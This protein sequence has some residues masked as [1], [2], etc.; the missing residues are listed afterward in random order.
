MIIK[1]LMLTLLS[2]LGFQSLNAQIPVLDWAKQIGTIYTDNSSSVLVDSIGNV[3]TS[4]SI[5]GVLDIDPGPDTSLVGTMGTRSLYI[6]KLDLNG[7]LLWGKSIMSQE[8]ISVSQVVMDQ[9]GHLILVGHFSDSVDFD[10]GVGA[11]Y[12][13]DSE[14]IMDVFILKLDSNGEFIWVNQ[15][16]SVD[17]EERCNGVAVDVM[18]NVYVIGRFYGTTD[19]DPGPDTNY[20]SAIGI[21]DMFINKFDA[22]GNFIWSKQILGPGYGGGHSIAVDSLGDLYIA[23]LFSL[24]VDFDPGIDITTLT[25]FEGPDPFILKLKTDG[26]LDW[27]K[28]I[29]AS[30]TTIINSLTLDHTANIYI[31]GSF[32]DTVDFNYGLGVDTF[33]SMGTSDVFIQKITTDGDYVW[34]KHMGSSSYASGKSIVTDYLGNIYTSGIFYQSVDFDPGL[35]TFHVYVGGLPALFIQKLDSNGHFIWVDISKWGGPNVDVNSIF[36]D[37]LGYVY[38]TG[39]FTQTIGFQSQDSIV[40][41]TSQGNKD[42]F[43]Q[44]IAQCHPAPLEPVTE[45]L[46]P[47]H[48]YCSYTP[49]FAPRANNG[50]RSYSGHT[51]TDFPI[52]DPTITEITWTYDDNYGNVIT[53]SQELNLETM[54]ISTVVNNQTITANNTNGIYQWLNCDQMNPIPGENAISFTA[55][56]NGNYALEIKENGCIDTTECISINTVYLHEFIDNQKMIV[57]PN[58]SKNT[59]NIQFGRTIEFG[60]I[61]ITDLQ[62]RLILNTDIKMNSEAQIQFNQDSGLYLLSVKTVKG[63][64][65]MILIKE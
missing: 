55:T 8:G 23:G 28:Q 62:G 21:S 29:Q 4:G 50:C 37:H 48:A 3:Y 14:N 65:T 15:I 24:T 64:N 51:T 32:S 33:I 11:S 36:T 45:L 16:G 59:F 54:D 30:E 18:G 27:V 52:T 13:G 44:K 43:V 49:S 17:V 61:T 58:P 41:L 1:V 35:D 19:F 60:E 46:L 42:V 2:T 34:T 6:Q 12:L 53:Q 10:P 20:V 57:S 47:I 9:S 25:A 22:N 56:T 40:Y 38:R 63:Q 7:E 26:T 31:T 39:R 5:Y